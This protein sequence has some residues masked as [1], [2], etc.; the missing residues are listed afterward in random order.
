M[1]L[2]RPDTRVLRVNREFERLFPDCEL[3]AMPPLGPLYGQ[4]VF[5]DRALANAGD[6]VFEAGSHTEAV[7]VKFDEFARAVQPTVGD[8]G[9][10]R[11]RMIHH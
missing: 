1:Q 2:Y 8:I 7:R 9:R 4:R 10:L 5:V 6:I 11:V 3:G